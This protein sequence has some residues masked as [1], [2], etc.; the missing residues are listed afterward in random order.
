MLEPGVAFLRRLFGEA[1]RDRRG[2]VA[3][4]FAFGLLL[5][6][7]AVLGAFDVTDRKSVV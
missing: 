1:A 6:L 5:V 4:A 7:V 2:A 3:I